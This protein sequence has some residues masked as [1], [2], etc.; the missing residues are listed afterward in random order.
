MLSIDFLAYLRT[1]L[2]RESFLASFRGRNPF[3]HQ[4]LEET[5]SVFRLNTGADGWER[6]PTEEGVREGILAPA[7]EL[8]P[9]RS[10]AR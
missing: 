3:L 10:F 7:Q 2:V 5:V 1:V 9:P 4:G 6:I 8:P